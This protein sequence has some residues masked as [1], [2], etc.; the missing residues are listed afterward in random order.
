MDEG[1]ARQE[2]ARG[3]DRGDHRLV[4]VAGLAV[5]PIDRAAGEQR[6]PRQIDP[7]RPDRVRHRQPIGLAELE[8]VGAMA[9][10]DVDEAGALVG[11]DKARRQ[12]RHLEL[13]ALAPERVARDGPGEGGAGKALD[14]RIGLDPAAGGDRLGQR[15]GDEQDLA[16]PRPAAF[17]GPVDPHRRVFERRAERD[18]AVAGQ[19]PRRRRPDQRRRVDQRRQPG[20]DD[21]KPH[22]NGRRF[23]VVI[24]DLGLG[25]R[26]LLDHRPQHRLRAAVEPAIHQKL[27]DL[28][29]D[30][31]LG[32]KSHRRIRVGPVADDAQSLELG[33]L[34]LDPVRGELAAFAAE[35]V[36]R[37]AVLRH[38]PRPVLFL[39]HPFDRQA[40]AVPARHIGRVLAQHLLRAVDHVLQDL[41]QRVADME[42]AVGVRRAVMQHEF[43]ASLRGL[44]QPAVQ[45]H[46]RPAREDRRLALWQIAAH[47]KLG[48]GQKD[49][50]TIIRRHRETLDENRKATAP[51][52]LRR[53][54]GR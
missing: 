39:D 25:Q 10:R 48:L 46:R 14:Q 32:R 36:G 21:W 2:A 22:P 12:Q 8:I 23:V 53:G 33:L 19:G 44:A 31:R 29:D 49:G 11:G 34:H 35:L 52:I 30:L 51:P 4:G 17:G 24:F 13:V 47:R 15:C 1:G 18:R 41:V 27:A 54:P 40:V 7:V 38:L 45:I 43:L 3:I 5:R 37:D 16:R 26:G 28:A 9:W 20:A 42:M 50:R 6:H